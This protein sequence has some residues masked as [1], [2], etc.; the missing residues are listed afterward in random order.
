MTTKKMLS[1]RD[2]YS[3]TLIKLMETDKSLIVCDS[4]LVN[5]SGAKAIFEKYPNRT[6]NFGISE[7]NMAAA[8]A[9]LSLTGLKPI[10]HSFAPFV[11]RRIMDQ[12]YVS[13]GFSKLNCLIY[14]SDPGYWSKYNG[15]THTTFEDIAIMSSIPEMTVVA[16]CDTNEF[17]WILEYY[18]KHGG[19]I[20]VRTPRQEVPSIFNET[21][22]FEYGKAKIIREGKDIVFLTSGPEVQDAIEASDYLEEYG[23]NAGIVDLMFLKPLD[24]AVLDEILSKYKYIITIENHDI[25]GGFG[26]QIAYRIA[27]GNYKNN[28]KLKS[29]AVADRYGE[30]GTIEYLK[31]IFGLDKDALIAAAMEI[32]NKDLN[33]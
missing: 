5:S 6:V 31:K 1:M 16:P 28:P 23:I 20:Y 30:V 19:L 26:Q 2:C 29:L 24:E 33:Y 12:V 14:G 4:D 3:N 21:V 9:G 11:T 17:R 22:K 18:S 32:M 7:S 10:I 15:P 13:L 8:A 27:T 25:L